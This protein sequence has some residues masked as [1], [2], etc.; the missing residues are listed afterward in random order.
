[1][2]ENIVALVEAVLFFIL[3]VGVVYV[4]VE[5]FKQLIDKKVVEKEFD[6]LKSNFSEFQNDTQEKLDS[7]KNSIAN[8]KVQVD[9]H[10]KTSAKILE[11]SNQDVEQI[12][13]IAEKLTDL[14]ENLY[15]KVAA[16]DQCL[17]HNKPIPKERFDE[18]ASAIQDDIKK[19]QEYKQRIEQYRHEQ[20]ERIRQ[21]LLRKKTQD[22]NLE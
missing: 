19:K 18:L 2:E 10:T 20:N 8:L 11:K 21:R 12:L 3:L 5:F 14:H 15:V 13:D 4:I 22:F 6:Q 9:E 16:I 7:Y 1:M 17:S